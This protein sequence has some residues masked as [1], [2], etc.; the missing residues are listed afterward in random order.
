MTNLEALDRAIRRIPGFPKP[1]VLFYD[2][3][4]VLIA[5]RVFSFCVREMA[6]TCKAAGAD[7]VAGVEARGFVFAGAIAAKLGVPLILV[8]KKGKL[9]G[10]TLSKKY[11]LEYGVE[12]I[13]VHRADIREGARV[14]LVDDLIATGGTLTAARSLIE[15]AGGTVAG[16]L[17]VIGLPFLH[18]EEALK[19]TPV[20]TLI[21]FDSE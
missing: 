21:N 9:P 19:P 4:G 1:G 18:Y 5:P 13:E 7:A 17:G 14:M 2:I 15:D 12:E 8:R 10:R 20:V 16:F 11:A 3:T 6:K